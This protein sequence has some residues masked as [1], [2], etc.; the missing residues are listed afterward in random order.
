MPFAFT[1]FSENRLRIW[2]DVGQF[3][4]EAAHDLLK[5]AQ[6]DALLT[7]LQPVQ[8]RGTKPDPFGEH[9]VR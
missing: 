3:A 9:G 7:Q 5:A 2:K 8:R 6:S 4:T 1:L